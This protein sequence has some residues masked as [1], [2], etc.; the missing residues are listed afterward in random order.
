MAVV[1]AGPFCSSLEYITVAPTAAIAVLVNNLCIGGLVEFRIIRNGF[2]GNYLK[3]S[4]VRLARI[5]HIERQFESIARFA[6][7]FERRC[8][9]LSVPAVSGVRERQIDLRCFAFVV[10][11]Q[12]R[13][14]ANTAPTAAVGQ[15]ERFCKFGN[16][17][18][19]AIDYNG[20]RVVGVTV[21]PL[22]K[23][24]FAYR[25]G[26]K[27]Q[28]VAFEVRF[29]LVEARYRAQEGVFRANVDRNR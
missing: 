12:F 7:F 20:A 22:L 5:F 13:V 28:G 23:A 6:Q 8:Y 27:R 25:S 29:I 3:H 4:V 1:D 10:F 17:R 19:I 26:G 15:F 2:P 9:K 14:A 11:G 18:Q 21:A 16:Q 24:E